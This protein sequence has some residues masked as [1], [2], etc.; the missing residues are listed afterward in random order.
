MRYWHFCT[1]V[2]LKFFHFLNSISQIFSVQ[3]CWN[4]S[5]WFLALLPHYFLHF[6]QLLQTSIYSYKCEGNDFTSHFLLQTQYWFNLSE[7]ISNFRNPRSRTDTILYTKWIQL[8]R[9]TKSVILKCLY[10]IYS[11]KCE[12]NDFTSHFLLQTQYWFNLSEKISNFRNPR[13]RTDT[14]LYTK[15]IQLFRVTKSVILKCLDSIYSYK[16]E[17]NHFTLGIKV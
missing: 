5:I 15:W 3:R 7:K 9:V 6:P 13:S 11:Y 17:G 12:G 8:F 10:S 2:N 16:C 14:I 1:N 4:Y